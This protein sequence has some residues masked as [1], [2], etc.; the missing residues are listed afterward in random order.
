MTR[1]LIPAFTEEKLL[2]RTN[3]LLTLISRSFEYEI[4]VSL[5]GLSGHACEL[6]RFLVKDS[7]LAGGADD[8]T[9]ELPP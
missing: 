1:L 2:Y 3:V 7:A 8:L 5:E 6:K 4:C 9:G